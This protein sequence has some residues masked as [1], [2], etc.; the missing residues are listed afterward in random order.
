MRITFTVPESATPA[1]VERLALRQWLDIR[2]GAEVT[3]KTAAA[4]K[5]SLSLR[6]FNWLL[7]RLAITFD[8]LRP[9]AVDRRFV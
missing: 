5:L 7:K 1:D 2:L 6:Q 9:V 8:D 3:T 4:M